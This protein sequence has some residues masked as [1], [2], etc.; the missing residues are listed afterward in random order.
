VITHNK[1]HQNDD[2]PPTSVL[3]DHA[4]CLTELT[5]CV[6]WFLPSMALYDLLYATSMT[7]FSGLPEWWSAEKE[8]Y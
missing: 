1:K 2:Y 8:L 4:N 6:H 7:S 5:N 3:V